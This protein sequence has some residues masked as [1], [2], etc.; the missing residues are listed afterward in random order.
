MKHLDLDERLALVE[1]E[2]TPAHPHLA[3]CARC[4][5]EVDAA[6]SVL[7]EAAAVTVPEPSPLYWDVLSRRVSDRLDS[8]ARRR[9]AG[10]W[11]FWRILVP[12]SIAVG[13]LLIAVG[14]EQ[15]GR[16]QALAPTAA[17]APLGD[18]TD[19]VAASAD[20]EWAVL[21]HLAGE[22][23]LDT[24]ADRLGRP[25]ESAADSAIWE[26]NVQERVELAALLRLDVLN[27]QGRRE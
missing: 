13:V 11:P 4:R 22:F 23:D 21:V 24:L 6:R 25:G 17:V 7:A 1:G 26:L 27:G 19:A 2:K 9:V 16:H 20:G 8:E 3:A 14:V 18:D 5:T 10:G 15:G 12:L